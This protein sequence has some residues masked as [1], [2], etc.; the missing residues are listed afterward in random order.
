[1]DVVSV[2]PASMREVLRPRVWAIRI[3]RG[4][5]WDMVALLLGID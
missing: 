1:M 4:F 2:E 3:G 5:V